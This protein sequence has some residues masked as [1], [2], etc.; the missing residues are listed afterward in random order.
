MVVQP[1][2]Q[3]QFEQSHDKNTQ[4]K[5]L[6]SSTPLPDHWWRLFN[7]ATLDQY[8]QDALAHNT[9]L[10]VASA[11]LQRVKIGRAHV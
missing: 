4:G 5:P 10:R 3:A 6:Y 11:N 8:V 7:D 2:A 1:A 9:D